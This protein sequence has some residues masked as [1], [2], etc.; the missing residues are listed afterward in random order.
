MVPKSIFT[1]SVLAQYARTIR[2]TPRD[3]MVN[4]SL[5]FSC[6]VYAIAGLPSTWDQGASSV[7]PSLPGFQKQF[8]IESR[9]KA[10]DI[11]NFISI[12]YIGY[13]VGAAASFFVNDRIGRRWSFRL[14]AS[15]W[16]L[17]QV[18]ATL[19][20]GWPALYTARIASGIGI[21]SLSVTGPMSIVEI[22][23]AEIRGLLTAWYTIAMGVALF[24][25]IFCVY[26]TFLHL[27]SSRLQYQV[28]WFS[29]AIFMALAIVASFFICESPRWLM[30]ADQRNTA[31]QTL[32]DLRRLP[33]NHPRLQKEIK[34]IEDSI[35]GLGSSLRE[36]VKETF[37]VP[38]NL[39]RLQQSCMSYAM[40]QLSGANSV[41]SYFI[42]IM[43][44]IGV[45]G[46]TSHSMFLSGMYGFSKLT[47]SILASFFFID[48]LGR[49]RSLFVG[50][51]LQLVSHIYIGVFIKYHQEGPVSVA[52][53]EAAIAAIFFHAFGYAVGL[54]VL[55]YIFGGELWPNRIR[56]FG[57]AVTQTFHWLFIYAIKY[58][59]PSLLKKTDNWG[60][61]LFFA[62]WCFLSLIY[63][64]VMVPEVS[65][66][67]V[68]EIDHLFKGPWFNAYKRPQ[69]RTVIESV[70]VS[71]DERNEEQ[72]DDEMGVKRT[73]T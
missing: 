59:I 46:G 7:V 23:P 69:K 55:P 27:P 31:V 32:A 44:I 62:G 13:A 48:A 71:N 17:G 47:F 3:M 45:G 35:S 29:P 25:S 72:S 34:D 41:T 16:I 37:T 63:V 73:K 56:S 40:A 66:L 9:A 18:I 24:T 36:I 1:D 61:F 21:G 4:R 15:I 53:S 28:V 20:P 12:I 43:S 11:Q 51:T 64:F 26:G 58:S 39:R 8:D 30:M 57:G 10:E 50:I 52:A 54:F 68:E 5:L 70:E 22:A 49:R 42:P 19:S 2:A 60:A 65:G 33:T 6:A 67:S 14:Y 38:S